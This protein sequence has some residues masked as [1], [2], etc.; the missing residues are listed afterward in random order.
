MLRGASIFLSLVAII[1]ALTIFLL[2]ASGEELRSN[3]SQTCRAERQ[4]LLQNRRNSR[5]QGMLTLTRLK[6]INQLLAL[7]HCPLASN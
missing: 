3:M 6:L 4:L 5:R 1:F 2:P 7:L